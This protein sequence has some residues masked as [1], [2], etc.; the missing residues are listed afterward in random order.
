MLRRSFVVSGLSVVA[1]AQEPAYVSTLNV[2]N[3]LATVRD[4]KGR[5][6]TDLVKDDFTIEEQGR[7]QEVSYFTQQS[8]LPLILGLLVDTSLSQ[9]RVLE[10]ERKAARRFFGRVLRPEK[11]RAFVIQ[12]HREVELLQDLTA[13]RE[14]LDKALDALETPH[15][16]PEARNPF[17]FPGGQIP[18]PSGPFPRPRGGDRRPRD[19][20]PTLGD[21]ARIAGTALYDAV[22]LAS[23]ELM[24]RQQGR[25]AL[26][27]V[28][29][30]VD[31]G[32]K[33]SRKTAVDAALRSDTL[34][35]SIRFTDE[36]LA[37]ALSRR[38]GRLPEDLP[39]G[40]AVLE[41]ISTS[42]GGASFE[43]DKKLDDIF[44]KIEEE[45]R[46]QYNLGYKPD[47]LPAKGEFRTIRVTTRKKGLSVR[48]RS[49]YYA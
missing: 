15:R 2:V 44:D 18:I 49:G 31:M 37:R 33:V 30:G 36:R 17:Q 19:G 25:K 47:P 5:I 41:A 22:L 32:S 14:E 20:G 13:L 6:V 8:D 21:G 42:T 9:T 4:D 12:F 27:V 48:S 16:A 45:L 3:V 39:D 43:G 10:T 7:V 46:N 24:Q 35:Y 34:V 11:D 1:R 40:K 29:D 23:E 28:S 26:V 38:G